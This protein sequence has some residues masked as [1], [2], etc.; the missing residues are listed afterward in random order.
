MM[1]RQL[2]IIKTKGAAV[3]RRPSLEAAPDHPAPVIRNAGRRAR[4]GADTLGNAA[5]PHR[6]I[7]VDHKGSPAEY[8]AGLTR[9]APM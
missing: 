9:A 6:R 1:D 3:S 4:D 5:S 7:A 8:K 2:L